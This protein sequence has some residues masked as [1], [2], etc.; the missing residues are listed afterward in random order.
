MDGTAGCCGGRAQPSQ[1]RV[2]GIA[3]GSC[4]ARDGEAGYVADQMA[5]PNNLPDRFLGVT[6]TAQRETLSAGPGNVRQAATTTTR[7]DDK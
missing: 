5:N 3:S 1:R 2:E 7:T 4:W 6:H